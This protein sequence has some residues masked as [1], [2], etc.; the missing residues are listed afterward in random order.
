MFL[1]GDQP[2][3]SKSELQALNNKTVTYK[4]KEMKVWEAE[5]RMRTIER[6]VR[7]WRRQANALKEA[8]QDNSFER[9]KEKKWRTL[10]N[11]FSEETG[12]KKQSQRLIVRDEKVL[13]KSI[14]SDKIS[15]IKDIRM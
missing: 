4:D 10:Y 13:Q 11:E 12:V 1:P 6:N 3:Y 15:N 9:D 14:K 5:Q 8:G 7:S 2:N